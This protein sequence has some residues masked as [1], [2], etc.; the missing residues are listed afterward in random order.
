MDFTNHFFF[1]SAVSQYNGAVTLPEI[2]DI[3]ET[4]GR[5]LKDIGQLNHVGITFFCYVWYKS[6]KWCCF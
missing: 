6:T 5:F 2:A 3:Y 1:S 4:L